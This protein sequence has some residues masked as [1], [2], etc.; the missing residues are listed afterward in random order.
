MVAFA[1]QHGKHILRLPIDKK[2]DLSEEDKCDF[3]NALFCSVAYCSVDLLYSFRKTD[4]VLLHVLHH[5]VDIIIAGYLYRFGKDH[6]RSYYAANKFDE[7]TL[8]WSLI[9]TCRHSLLPRSI[10]PFWEQSFL[11]FMCIFFAL[12]MI[13]HSYLL[14]RALKDE[15]ASTTAGNVG[16][17]GFVA[18]LLLDWKYF[19]TVMKLLKK[20]CK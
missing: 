6:T 2:M 9:N 11:Y 7:I 1:L 16:K 18:I 14:Q 10:L 5:S 4:G 19:K 15:H 3:K 8:L 20:T 12:R 17:I 13:L